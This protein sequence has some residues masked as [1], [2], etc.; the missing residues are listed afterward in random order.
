MMEEELPKTAVMKE[1]LQTLT[2]IRETADKLWHEHQIL[3]RQEGREDDAYKKLK[4]YQFAM[5][6]WRRANASYKAKWK[7]LRHR[8]P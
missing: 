3:L 2:K 8:N 4:A 7:Q 1:L 6:E 5:S